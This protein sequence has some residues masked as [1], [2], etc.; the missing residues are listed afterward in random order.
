MADQR[1]RGRAHEPGHDQEATPDPKESRQHPDRK[2]K[3]DQQRQQARCAREGQ[4]HSGITGGPAWPQH[5]QPDHHH[6]DAEHGKKPAAIDHLAEGGSARCPDRSKGRKDDGARPLHVSGTGMTEQI[7]RRAHC[8]RNRAG[9]DRHVRRRDADHID[10]KRDREDRPAPADQPEREADESSG[11]DGQDV[12]EAKHCCLRNRALT[13]IRA[14]GGASFG[15]PRDGAETAGPAA[16]RFHGIATRILAMPQL[17]RNMR[18]G[19][20]LPAEV[21]GVRYLKVPIELNEDARG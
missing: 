1:H 20:L 21:N 19:R 5:K 11:K 9:P 15:H 12:S 2:S 6:K 10:Q 18:A 3:A 7:G 4:P 13:H 16:C 14:Q 8:H 17:P